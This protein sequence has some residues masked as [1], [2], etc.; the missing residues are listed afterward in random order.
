MCPKVN[1]LN[2]KNVYCGSEKCGKVCADCLSHINSKR[3]SEQNYM[4]IERW[5]NVFGCFLRRATS[6]TVPSL[7]T[8]K[9]YKKYFPELKVRVKEHAVGAHLRYVYQPDFAKSEVM[10]IVAIG[11]IGNHKGA[12]HIYSLEKYISKNNLPIRITVLGYTHLHTKYYKSDNGKFEVT[13]SYEASEI[14]ELLKDLK[15]AFVLPQ[16]LTRFDMLK[17]VWIHSCIYSLQENSLNSTSTLPTARRTA[18]LKELQSHV[19]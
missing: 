18:C 9:V 6:V 19:S 7:N 15:P 13:G 12:N 1:L 16:T 5:R 10:H 4:F 17:D 2:E 11:G 14:S 8:A 3:T